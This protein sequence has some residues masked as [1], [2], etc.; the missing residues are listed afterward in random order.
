MSNQPKH[1]VADRVRV[2]ISQR[3]DIQEGDAG[4][5]IAVRQG[6]DG[7]TWY[8]DVILDTG[9][10]LGH[11]HEGAFIGEDDYDPTIPF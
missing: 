10:R 7:S 3:D 8:V 9:Y 4:T 11:Y 1:K 5:V 6:G 2:W